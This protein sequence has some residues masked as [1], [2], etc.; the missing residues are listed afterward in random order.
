LREANLT[1]ALLSRTQAT[2]TNFS[3]AILQDANFS[4]ANLNGA[5]FKDAH[6]Q[7]AI[8]IGAKLV[9]ADF[10]GLKHDPAYLDRAD[11]TDTGITSFRDTRL[12]NA[13]MTN[14]A[15]S[16]QGCFWPS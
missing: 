7:G 3:R 9:A 15:I 12:C 1:D 6:L 16:K 8:M 11:L 14:G 5:R 4:N 2:R 10:S 13:T